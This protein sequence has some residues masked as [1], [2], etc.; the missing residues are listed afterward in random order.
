MA[1]YADS[2]VADGVPL[3]AVTRHML[4]LYLVSGARNCGGGGS[5]KRRDRLDGGAPPGNRRFL[6]GACDAHCRLIFNSD[7][8]AETTT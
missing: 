5:A 7:P 4:G 2:F 6:R 1:D 3:H 8:P